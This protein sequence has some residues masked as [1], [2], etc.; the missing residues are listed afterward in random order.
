[1]KT[2]LITNQKG[3]TGK[4]TIAVN[5][6]QSFKSFCTTAILDLD[7]QGSLTSVKEHDFLEGVDFYD[8]NN[9]PDILIVD[10]PPYLSPT[11][12][13]W[14]IKA[15]VIIIPIKP[16]YLDFMATQGTF[17]MINDLNKKESV[18]VVPNLVNSSSIITT[19]IINH[20]EKLDFEVSKT[21]LRERVSFTRSVMKSDGIYSSSDKKA[22]S[23]FES[24]C[25]EI[26]IKLN[27]IVK[28]KNSYYG[29]KA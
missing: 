16:S 29:K 11:L 23:E 10:S 21:L 22:I 28:Y 2:I 19:S 24:L 13:E 27:K 15:D 20:V 25:K 6:S 8:K 9:E 5:L 4:S 7:Q 3:G 18:L 17:D 26:L 14:I 12:K 1:M